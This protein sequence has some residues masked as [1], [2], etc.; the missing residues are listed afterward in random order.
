[1]KKY[2]LTL[3]IGLLPF[4]TRCQ[5]K[6]QPIK[7]FT[8][9]EA[10]EAK[11]QADVYFKEMNYLSALKLFERLVVTDPNNAEYNHKLGLSYLNT[12]LAK[13]KAVSYLEFAANANT[14]VKPKDVAFDLARAYHYAGLYDKALETYE[15][16]RTE[17]KGS[18]DAKLRFDMHVKWSENARALR[19]NPLQAGFENLGKGI[20][21]NQSEYR[22]VMGIADTVIYF[23]S[24][25]KGATGGLTD[26]L[27]DTPSDIYFFTQNDTSRSKVKNAGV[28][29]NTMYYEEILFLS[30]SGDKMLV[31]MEG[32]EA[33]GDIYIAQLKG[34]QWTKPALLGKDFQTKVLE[35]GASLSPDGLT[36]YFAAEAVDG[37]TGK[38]IYKCERTEST[39]WGKPVRL[40]D[41]I[42]TN[43][44]EDNPQL[45]VDGKTLFFS[46]TG[47][48]SMGGLDVFR[49]VMKDP[50]E[51]FGKPENIGYPLN[52][53]YDDMG[54]AIS[55]DGKTVYTAAVRDSGL[56]D[57]DLYKV[58][59]EKP[60]VAE[61]VCWL[62]GKAYSNV[63][64]AAK[65][66]FVVISDVKTGATLANLET[67]EATGRF[68]VALPAGSYKVVLKHAKLGKA[69]T[70]VT[71]DPATSGKT[72]VE[73]KFP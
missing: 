59:L 22:P 65:G 9:D 34:K 4:I 13:H 35:S 40:G 69:E 38:D 49:A 73:L 70:E 43:G 62:Q 47:H 46:S 42:N 36:L 37:K 25:R 71:V 2:F 72:V 61:P 32:P 6:P 41:N 31:Y 5:T 7:P 33:S 27:G 8:A 60:I 19:E 15:Q 10:K 63:G 56:G 12:N 52:T 45:W 18:V 24:R 53:E 39:S 48:N 64:T 57:Y 29:L 44:D 51:G 11:K 58:T 28:N 17:K 66:A 26:E 54:I 1:M 23:S 30:A 67:N 55:A 20:N 68:D 50:R 3:L 14:K 16:Y 21:T